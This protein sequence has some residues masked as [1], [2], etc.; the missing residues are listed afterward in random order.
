MSRLH[1]KKGLDK[2]IPAFARI[3]NQQAMLVIAGPDSDGYQA[4]VQ[5]MIDGLKLSDRVLFAGMLWN[6]DRI[7]ALADADLFVLPSY[8]ENFGI[9]VIESLA[10]GTPVIISDQV[11]IHREVAAAGV[12]GVVPLDLNKLAA[13]LDRWIADPSLR[14]AASARAIVFA[15]S[16]YDWAQI[17]H[18]W[19]KHYADLMRIAG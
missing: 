7:A 14:E 13:E 12:G 3:K 11:N 9:A 8:Q 18:N 10:A 2:L 5:Q 17:A 16:R 6:A 15:Q 19:R 1:Y 4:T